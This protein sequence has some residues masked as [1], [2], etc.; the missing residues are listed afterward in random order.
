M[1]HDTQAPSTHRS[2]AGQLMGVSDTARMGEPIENYLFGQ[3]VNLGA[4]EIF[5]IP[6]LCG[7]FHL[8]DKEIPLGQLQADVRIKIDWE[9][10]AN[11][12][13]RGAGGAVEFSD[14]NLPCIMRE[15]PDSVESAIAK[16]S[17]GGSFSMHS[18]DYSK[19][20]NVIPADS[21]SASVLIPCRVSSLSTILH[22][23]RPTANWANNNRRGSRAP[24][25]EGAATK[26][27]ARW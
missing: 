27:S 2:T 4:T 1:L 6:L 19:Y 18:K 12:D 20:M 8:S 11:W 16:T 7:L 5:S 9:Q 3:N 13:C 23:L 26:S 22:C 17:Q 24:K 14:I 21:G 10:T 25:E 15:V